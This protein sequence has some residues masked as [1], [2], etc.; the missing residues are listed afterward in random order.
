MSNHKCCPGVC[1]SVF[2]LVLPSHPVLEASPSKPVEGHSVTLTCKI[3]L[4]A[5]RQSVQFCFS[6]NDNFLGSGCSSSPKLQ[7]PALWRKWPDYYQCIAVTTSLTTNR[8]SLPIRIPVQ[9]IPVSDV[10]LKTRPPGGRVMEGNRLVL[11][12]SVANA[13]GNITYLWYRGARGSNL[14][15]KTQHSLTAEFEIAEVKRSDAQQYYCAADNGYGPVPSELV[16][17][18]IRVP[19]SRPVLTLG[20]AGG[21]AVPGAL[22]ELRC[23]APGGSPPIFYRFFHEAVALGNASAPSG[24]G[25]SL[26]LSLRAE[27]SGAFSCEASNGG[28]AQRSAAV[29]LNL[30]GLAAAENRR[31]LPP[32]GVAAWLLGCLGLLTVALIVCYW[33]KRR[34]GRQLDGPVGSLCRP[35]S[36]ESSYL[37]S[38]DSEQPLP[39]Y[40][41]VSAVSGNEVY[42]LVYCTQQELDPAAAQH[43]RTHKTSEVSSERSSKPRNINITYVDYGDTM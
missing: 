23:E 5:Q 2:S 41:N 6:C 32:S 20:G 21:R 38:P 26:N 11:I 9:R 43:R 15:T 35:V 17:I 30:T 25:A 24:G 34:I 28:G 16:S 8:W 10:S 39:V 3:H 31:R 27:H 4:P 22:V 7:I 14:G 37:N 12:C 13:T 42:S 29:P 40:E 1:V 19:V 33:L 36:Q 18:D